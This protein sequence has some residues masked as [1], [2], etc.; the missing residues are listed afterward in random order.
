MARTCVTEVA[1]LRLPDPLGQERPLRQPGQRVVPGAVVQ[2]GLKVLGSLTSSMCMMR[3]AD[4]SMVAGTRELL[5]ITQTT[6]VRAFF[7][8]PDLRHITA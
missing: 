5:T 7:A 6:T 8:D 3:C 2:L 4:R 1:G